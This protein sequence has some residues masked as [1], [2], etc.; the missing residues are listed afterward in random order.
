MI[1]GEVY[2]T[3]LLDSYKKTFE[4]VDKINDIVN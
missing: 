4:S 2:D 3:N 1:K